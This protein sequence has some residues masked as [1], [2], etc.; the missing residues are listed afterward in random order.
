M[1]I[2]AERTNATN[3]KNEKGDITTERDE[4]ERKNVLL[5]HATMSMN[6]KTFS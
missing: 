1:T 2:K 3:I 4:K 5:I 6:L